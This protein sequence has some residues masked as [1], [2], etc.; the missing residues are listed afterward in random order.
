M[1]R[2]VMGFRDWG[3]ER[4]NMGKNIKVVGLKVGRRGWRGG[5]QPYRQ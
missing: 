2:N 1:P 5:G 4:Y 3:I